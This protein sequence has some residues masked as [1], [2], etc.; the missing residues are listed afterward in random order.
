MK[1]LADSKEAL[2]M[3]RKARELAEVSAKY[4]GRVKAAEKIIDFFGV[5]MIAN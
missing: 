4:G 2:A 3:R 5:E 1:V